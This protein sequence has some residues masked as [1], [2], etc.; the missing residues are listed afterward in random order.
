MTNPLAAMGARILRKSQTMGEMLGLLK[1]TVFEIP[2]AL[3][4]PLRVMSQMARVGQESLPIAAIMAIFTGMVLALHS[5]YAL[6]KFGAEELLATIVSLSVVKEMA[7]VL[8]GLLLAGRVGAA[9]AAELGT[10]A[11]N[12]EI[13]ALHTLGVS[14]V[15]YL[16]MP[17]FLACIV[18]A[19]VLVVYADLIGMTGGAIIANNYF[20]ITF[21]TY[22]NKVVDAIEFRELFEGLIKA[23][24]FGGIIA[25][26]SCHQGLSTKGGAEGVG[27]AI[28]SA[29]VT[30][31]ICIFVADYFITNFI[32]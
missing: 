23:F 14:P 8:T 21:N 17:R 12:E 31:F 26:V 32:L 3:R 19:P 10:M 1:R 5:G 11:V 18:M 2:K 28:T 27:R 24:T 6:L 25:I 20:D 29:V 13:D 30:S 16:V 22:V 7:P 15:R 4:H 9:F